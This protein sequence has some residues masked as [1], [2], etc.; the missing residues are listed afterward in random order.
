M[1]QLCD[2]RKHSDSGSVQKTMSH[3]HELRGGYEV[4]S[5]SGTRR[6]TWETQ[7]F[8]TRLML[9]LSVPSVRL[10]SNITSDPL[11]KGKFGLREQGLGVELKRSALLSPLR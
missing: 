2:G 6:E 7:L 4:S 10:K 1:K 3:K 11:S 5:F 8:S 9:L